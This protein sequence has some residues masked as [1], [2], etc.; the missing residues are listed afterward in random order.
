MLLPEKNEVNDISLIQGAL[1]DACAYGPRGHVDLSEK[2]D[3]VNAWPL[4]APHQV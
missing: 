3:L 4:R 2:F 1:L